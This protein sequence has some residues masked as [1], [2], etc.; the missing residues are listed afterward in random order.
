MYKCNEGA[1]LQVASQCEGLKQGQS[2]IISVHSS[3][4]PEPV[5][6]RRQETDHPLQI[7]IYIVQHLNVKVNV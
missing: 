5:L 2:P 7:H 3:G 1:D 6:N 4:K